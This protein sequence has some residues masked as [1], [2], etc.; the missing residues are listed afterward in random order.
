LAYLKGGYQKL[1]ENMAKKIDTLGGEIKMGTPFDKKYIKNFD[2]IIFTGPSFVFTTIFPDIPENYIK[3]LR[4]I[5]HLHA[6]NMLL[7]TKEKFLPKS[8]WLNINNRKMPFLAVVA[9]TNFVDSKYYG[10]KHLT[11]IGN[12]LAPDHPYLKMSKE[13]LFKLFLPYLKK[14]NPNFNFDHWLLD[15]ELFFGPFAQPVFGINYSKIKPEFEAPI[16]NVYLANMDMVYPWDRGTNYA[17]ELGYK[18][19]EY[20]ENN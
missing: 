14:I 19:A 3:R 5:P 1:M 15:I 11:W 18:A 6:L 7:I 9:H 2:K 4:S 17:I 12:Y 16:K 20:I 8:Y 10:G 13:E